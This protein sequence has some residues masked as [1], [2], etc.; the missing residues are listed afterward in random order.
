MGGT[1]DPI[2][3]GHLA[4]AN[5]VADRAS[6]DVVLFVPT[7]W[8]WQKSDRQ[9]SAAEDRLAMTLLAIEGNPHFRVS[10]VEVDHDGPSY[11]VDTMAKLAQQHAGDELFFIA[12]ADALSNLHTWHEAPR[13]MQQVS[14]IAVARAGHDAPTPEGISALR[15]EI[16]QLEISS[17]DIRQRVRQGRSIRYLVP[18]PVADYIVRNSLYA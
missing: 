16:P 4:A 13:L 5:D 7:G 15:V 11:T 2:H 17:S 18:D 8:S 10:R 14:F 6:L 12:G 9:V 3:L 1:F